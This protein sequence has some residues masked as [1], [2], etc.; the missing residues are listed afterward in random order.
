MTK[1][2]TCMNF[3]NSNFKTI[4]NLY[5]SIN[6]VIQND[7]YYRL[8]FIQVINLSLLAIGYF[9]LS[10]IISNDLKLILFPFIVI[11]ILLSVR[12]NEYLT[13]KKQISI[14]K[15]EPFKIMKLDELSSFIK[16]DELFIG[17][18]FIWQKHDTKKCL[19]LIEQ[20]KKETFLNPSPK[21]KGLR[22]MQTLSPNVELFV[23]IKFFE[24]HTL[25][26][27]TTGA[28]KTR[29]FDL[30]IAQAIM[31]NESVIILDPKGDKDL[32]EHARAVADKFDKKLFKY[33]H[34]G[35]PKESI[36]INPL[37]NYNRA[38]E[39]SSR[40][41]ALIPTAKG[42]NDPFKSFAQLALN[43]VIQALIYCRIR[44]T[45]RIIRYY[46]DSRLYELAFLTF[47]SFF[48]E[49]LPKKYEEEWEALQK[50]VSNAPGTLLNRYNQLYK[51]A[52]K[53]QKSS[54]EIE[55]LFILAKHD[56]AHYGKMIGSLISVLDAL[57]IGEL[58]DL[59]SPSGEVLYDVNELDFERLIDKKC[60]VYVGLD[61]LTDNLVGSSLGSLFLADLT[62]VAGSRYNYS[63]NITP[64]NL[65][66]DES[67][68]VVSDEL[69]QLLNKGR[70]AGFR[71]TIATQ[72]IADFE[73]R[74]GSKAKASQVLGNLNNLISLRIIDNDTKEYISNLLPKIRVNMHSRSSSQSQSS[75]N[76]LEVKSDV[77]DTVSEEEISIFPPQLLSEL[78]DLEFVAKIGGSTVYKGKLPLIVS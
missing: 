10:L 8:K 70:G 38:T 75:K 41:A 37:Y 53:T 71:L 25:I 9:I 49:N 11:L 56:S 32:C 27:G 66:V 46:I 60:I 34:P 29:L 12:V 1:F 74:L 40:I 15:G 39:L 5:N 69:I 50:T 47:K 44:P 28:G 63:Y 57:T 76:L 43:T 4:V 2:K 61:S 24:G 17:D 3:L 16:K 33:F 78:P 55:S 23:P 64:V 21:V 26:T 36:K 59:L 13:Y 72:T 31:R 65:Y 35:F 52:I 22:F 20:Y 30:L 54:N 6:S 19:D 62:S 42:T 45:L 67:A 51:K 18:G 7:Y 58:G 77:S 68:E 14:L 73:A 48:D